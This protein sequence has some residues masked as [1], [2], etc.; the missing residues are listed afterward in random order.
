VRGTLKD[1]Q[2]VIP[3]VSVELINVANGQTRET[4]TNETGQYAF[5]A[6]DP[7]RYTLRV[8]VQGFKPYENANVVIGTQQ[9]VTLDVT[10]EVGSIEENITV[11]GQSPLIETTNASQGGTLDATDFKELPS[12]GRSVFSMAA[13]TPT[14]VASGNAHY[15][16]MQDQSGNS[17]LSMGG[18]AVRSNN[19][20]VDG[21]PTTDMQN[22]SS[23]NPSL[24]SL[25][26][27]RVQVHTYDA[28]MGRTGGGVMNMAARAGSNKLEGSAYT[29]F[30][31]ESLQSQLLI[32]RLNHETFRP[33][34]WRNAGGGIGGPIFKNRTFFYF[35]GE[36]YTD[37]QPQAST[38]SVPSMAD[39]VGDFSALMR[40]GRPFYLRD[41]LASGA[42][43]STTGG[44]GCFPGNIIPTSRLNFTGAKVASYMPVPD[45]DVDDGTPNFGRTDLLPSHAYQWTLKLNHNFNNAVALSVFYLRQVT[46]ENSANY[47]PVYKFVGSQFLLDRAD[48]TF[49][50]NNTWVMNSSTVFTLRGGWNE[51]LD[52]NVLPVPFDATTLWPVNSAFTTQFRDANRFPTTSLTGYRGTGWSNRSDN[53]YYQYGFNGAL[54]KLTGSHSLKAGGDYRILGVQSSSYGASTGSYSFDGRFTGNALADML[55]GYPSSGNI[56]I[57]SDLDGYIRYS[58]GFAQDDWR[59]NSRLTLNYGV[60]VEHETNLQERENRITTDFAMT[61]LSPLNDLVNIVDPITGLRRD[62][63]GGLL[64]AGQDGAPTQQGGTRTPQVSPRVGGV[65]SLTDKMVVRGGWGIYVAPWNYSSAGTTGWSQYGYSA[66]TELQQSSSGVPITTLSD[67]FPGRFVQPSGSALGMLTNVGASTNVR[68]PN[69]GTPKVQ[70]YSVDIEREFRGGV[71]LGA[72]YTG[73]TGRNLDWQTTININQLDPKYQALVPDTLVSVPNP[74]YGVPQAGQFASRQTI[75]LGQLLRPFPQFGDILWSDATGARSQYHA[76]VLQGRKRTDGLWGVTFSYTYSR[77]NDNQVGASNYYASAPGVQNNYVLVPWSSYYDPDSEYGRSLLDSPHKFVLA[78]T[79]VLPFGQGRK[80]LSQSELADTLLGGWSVTAVYQAQSGF[81]L[82]VNQNISGN[83]FLLGGTIRPDLVPGEAI[84]NDGDVTDRIR[85][86]PTDNQYFNNAAFKAVAKNT[87]GNAPRTLPGVLSPFRNSFSMSAAKHVNL[88]GRATASAR[89]E[90]LNPFNIVQWASLASSAVGNASFGQVRTQANN[91]R[92]IQFTFRVSY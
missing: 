74:F 76:L 67:P 81:P 44:P 59:V 34:Y 43:S 64:Y 69:K 9:F 3:G 22:R 73:L 47:N 14:V 18:G 20:L 10:L 23:V 12:E 89:V 38:F 60:R 91:M 28:E 70:Q 45:R 8:Q 57:S 66:T 5:P 92:S 53:T 16:R 83:Q 11:T 86:N 39:R 29:I 4:L 88:P 30:R 46:E 56:P 63:Y 13:L 36:R 68:L 80:F 50:V 37:L 49:V 54:S 72:G 71:M 90:L 32:P 55:L 40:N 6:V 41:P 33:E 31:P 65:L 35:A 17:A 25:Q 48:H 52:N 7:M 75:E 79:L 19:F 62:I 2:G 27:A 78:P 51:F 26:D 77:L 21:F 1:A 85:A 42:C 84:L 87:F 61:T 24:E 58:A 15:N 82:G